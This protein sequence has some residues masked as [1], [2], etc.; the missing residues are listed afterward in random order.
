MAVLTS[1][2]NETFLNEIKSRSLIKNAEDRLSGAVR[3]MVR[4]GAVVRKVLIPEYISYSQLDRQQDTDVPTKVVS[5]EPNSPASLVVGFGTP[6]GN[7][8]MT[9]KRVK[10]TFK[11]IE[12][13]QATYDI[14]LLGTYE[15]DLQQVFADNLARDILA[16]EDGGFFDGVNTLL[17]TVDTVSP[18]IP[19]H[20]PYVTINA[21][22][23]REGLQEMLNVMPKSIYRLPPV[24]AVINM[25]TANRL[26]S[27]GR[28]EIGGDKAQA[29]VTKG[30]SEWE[31]GGL[32]WV[33]TLKRHI[34]PDDSVYLFSDPRTIGK[35][36]ILTDTTTH[37]KTEA[38]I[39]SL[40]SFETIAS[41]IAHAGGVARVNF[42]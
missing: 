35:F 14:E 3:L 7:F 38:M 41:V 22:Y 30:F 25:I 19:G 26:M 24:T 8:W 39:L 29:L 36:Y 4:D 16:R 9:A 28:E 1:V 15:M 31:W 42:A 27:L 17:G 10:A 11:R 23:S 6:P 18:V 13:P 37:L 2:K 33:V 34:V 20:Y 40:F 12:T 32:R 5:V 21:G